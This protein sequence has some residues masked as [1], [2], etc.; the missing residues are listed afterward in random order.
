VHSVGVKVGETVENGRKTVQWETDHPVNFFN[1]VAARNWAVRKGEGTEIYYHPKHAY[2]IEEM[3]E[4]LD[5]S[6]KYFSEW[7]YPYPW[8]ELRLNEFPGIDFYAQGFPANI[9]FSEGIGFLTRSSPKAKA[10]FLVTAHEAAH[11]WWGNIL[12]PGEGPGG[13]IL[14]EGMAHYSTILLMNQVKGDAARIEFC[15]R[16][17]ER[18]GDRRQ[19]DSEKALVWIDGT[20]AGDE[21]TTY[22]KGGWVFWMLHNLMGEE[23]SRAGVRDF[24]GQYAVNVDHPVMQDYLRVMKSHAPDSAAFADFEKQWFFE[25]VAPEYKFSDA[26]K[27]SAGTAWTVRCKV[28]NHG[29]G[30]AA[31]DVA[32]V[33]GERFEKQSDE[34]ARKGPPAVTA[35]WRE[36][37]KSIVIGAGE[38]M[39][40]EIP[41]DFE[42][43]KVLVDPDA[44]VLQLNRKSALWEF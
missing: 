36:A 16:I 7:F 15:K 24:I 34:E 28:K 39:D 43:D 8:K 14:S 4:A 9:T 10:A 6:R 5:A 35:D 21:T 31:I 13:N 38:E 17:E 2:N 30:K 32:A 18:Y 12:L 37:R 25:V 3:G 42:P 19:V 11:Q 27:E 20:K 41:C 22:D 23:A 29:T 44:M 33:K 1:V 40:V 26:K